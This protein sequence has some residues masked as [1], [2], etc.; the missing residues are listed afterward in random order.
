[1]KLLFSI[2]IQT[3]LLLALMLTNVPL[4]ESVILCCDLLFHDSDLISYNECKL[5]HEQF[6]KLLNFAV[7]DAHFMFSKQLYNQIDGFTMGSSLGPSLANNFMCA[8]EQVS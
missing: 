3:L 1:M 6:C 8:L 5:S 2:L 4:T 7:K